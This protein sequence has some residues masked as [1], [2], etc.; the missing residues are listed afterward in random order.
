MT[1]PWPTRGY[2]T[3]EGKI[4]HHL[5]P[6]P[7]SKYAPK[8]EYYSH[9]HYH[10]FYHHIYCD[11]WRLFPSMRFSISMVQDHPLLYFCHGLWSTNNKYV[12]SFFLW[13]MTFSSNSLQCF[14]F[15]SFW[16]RMTLKVL[17]CCLFYDGC[18]YNL[19]LSWW[20][21]TSINTELNCNCHHHHRHHHRHGRESWKA[22]ST[23]PFTSFHDD[24]RT[25]MEI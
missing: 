20:V 2:Y 17:R 7:K 24:R 5:F 10:Y 11:I 1:R 14:V 8:H 6:E 3:M 4:M 22:A 23:G 18:L 12:Y 13:I 15:L 21:S 25:N 9:Y 19:P 16:L